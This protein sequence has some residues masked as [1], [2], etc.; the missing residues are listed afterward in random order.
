[1]FHSLNFGKK[2][3]HSWR[4]EIQEINVNVSFLENSNQEINANV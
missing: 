3:V 4:D 2:G 1:M